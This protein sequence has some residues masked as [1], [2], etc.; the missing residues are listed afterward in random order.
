MSNASNPKVD[1]ILCPSSYPGHLPFEQQRIARNV[2]FGRVLGVAR[3]HSQST[4][5]G[6]DLVTREPGGSRYHPTGHTAEGQAKYDWEDRASPPD[7]V[8]YGYLADAT[9]AS[10]AS[11]PGDSIEAGIAARKASIA[12]KIA[13]LEAI[14]PG[15][16]T[17][18]QSAE[19]SRLKY[20]FEAAYPT[21]APTPTPTAS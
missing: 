21:P 6:L 15:A 20:R 7:G 14:A 8:K 13:Q 4:P 3:V 1:A 18:D 9:K 12:A 11:A 19:L 16:R 10:P 2:E 17:A 5:G